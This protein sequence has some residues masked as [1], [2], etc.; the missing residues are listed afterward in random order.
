[1]TAVKNQEMDLSEMK[2]GE[3]R[4]NPNKKILSHG[5]KALPFDLPVAISVTRHMKAAAEGEPAGLIGHTLDLDAYTYKADIQIKFV[6]G[7]MV[8][9]LLD[10]KEIGRKK[11]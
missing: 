9:I 2:G 7:K 1:M 6:R 8:V 5:H 4:N 11:L 3:I 10:G